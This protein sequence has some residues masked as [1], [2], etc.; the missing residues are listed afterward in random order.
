MSVVVVPPRKRHL[1]AMFAM[2]NLPQITC[3]PFLFF[4][5]FRLIVTKQMLFSQ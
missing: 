5:F 2:F 4:F 1:V 3:R